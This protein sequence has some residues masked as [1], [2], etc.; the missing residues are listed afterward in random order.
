MVRIIVLPGNTNVQF[1]KDHDRP[2]MQNVISL[3]NPNLRKTI[4]PQ[5]VR[6]FW[7]YQNFP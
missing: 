6:N 7:Q 3:Q 2:D 1:F 4:L 5:K